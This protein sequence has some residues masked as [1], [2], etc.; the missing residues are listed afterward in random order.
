M[1][2]MKYW[3]GLICGC[4]LVSCAWGSFGYKYYGLKVESYNGTLQ[5]PS[6]DKNLPFST[7]SPT[8]SDQN[9]CAVLQSKEF[10]RLKSEVLQLRSDLKDCQKGR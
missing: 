10:F 7:C 2:L 8:P 6:A 3:V 1:G 4:F 5:G 9:P